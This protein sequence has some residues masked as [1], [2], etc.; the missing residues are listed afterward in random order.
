MFLQWSA[1]NSLHIHRLFSLCVERTHPHIG[2]NFPM[3]RRGPFPT[4]CSSP[5]KKEGFH[6]GYHRTYPVTCRIEALFLRCLLIN[7]HRVPW[8][9]PRYEGHIFKFKL[10]N[11]CG[12]DVAIFPR[13]RCWM[14][15]GGMFKRRCHLG[16]RFGSRNLIEWGKVHKG[17]SVFRRSFSERVIS[18]FHL[19]V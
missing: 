14:R 8:V 5:R 11:Y 1:W 13:C 7:V 16:F 19:S 15:V 2:Y 18:H 17:C 6:K 12:S 3:V 4:D 10:E 9:M